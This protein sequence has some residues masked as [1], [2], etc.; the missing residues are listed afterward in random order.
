MNYDLFKS[1]ININ[2][3]M[4]Y[5]NVYKILVDNDP[6]QSERYRDLVDDFRLMKELADILRQERMGRGALD[7]YFPETKVI[8]DEKGYP[9]DIQ[10]RVQGVGEMI[11]EDMIKANE[12]VAEHLHWQE[13]PSL[14]RVHEKPDEEA[15]T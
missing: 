9:I 12:T 3:R 2:E 14:Y 8:V 6:E 10:A 5:T 1:V 7:F 13:V 4:T 11:I 15:Q